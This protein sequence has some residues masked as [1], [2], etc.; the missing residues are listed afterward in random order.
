MTNSPPIPTAHVL[1]VEDDP[2]VALTIKEMLESDGYVVRHV[3]TGAKARAALEDPKPD[4]IVLD[5]M[6]PDVD[7][8]ILCADLKARIGAP[9]II[10]SGTNRKR[11]MVLALKLG[12][13]DFIGKPFDIDEFLTRTAAVLRRAG[14]GM[15]AMAQS[16]LVAAATAGPAPGNGG[17]VQPAPPDRAAPFVGTGRQENA[18]SIGPLCLEHTRRRVLF[19]EEGVQLTPTEYRLLATFMARP[20]I[21]LTRQELAQVVWGYEDASVGRSIDVHVHRLRAKLQSA[22]ESAGV[23]GPTVV[24]VRGFG[25]KLLRDVPSS[26]AA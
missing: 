26:M 15:V 13:D 8:L 19:G 10:C 22:Q 20:E 6:L 1:L 9:V 24:S 11:D 17:V 12:A 3:D 16:A 25:Y 7:G 21:V 4:L 14:T 18:V 2:S 23:P 5:L